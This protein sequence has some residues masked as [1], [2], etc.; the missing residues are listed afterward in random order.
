[1]TASV[2]QKFTTAM[3]SKTDSWKE[4]IHE[5]VTLIGALGEFVGFDQFVEVN[6]PFFAS[7]QHHENLQTIVQDDWVLTRIAVEVN[8]PS[9]KTVRLDVSEWYQFENGKIKYLRTYFDPREMI[10]EMS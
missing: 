3:L 1:M 4:F 9:G 8:T 2:Y 7:I 6:T 5:D 10:A